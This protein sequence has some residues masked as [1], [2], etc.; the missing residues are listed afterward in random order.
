[1]RLDSMG[2]KQFARDMLAIAAQLAQ[3]ATD[4][5]NP[6]RQPIRG[7]HKIKVQDCLVIRVFAAG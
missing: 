2:A 5:F 7:F 3:P 1:M 4:G 6:Y